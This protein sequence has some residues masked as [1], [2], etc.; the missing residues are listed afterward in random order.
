MS[1]VYVAENSL[2]LEGVDMAAG[3]ILRQRF[4]SPRPWLAAVAAVVA[5]VVLSQMTPAGADPLSP[6]PT[7]GTTTGSYRTGLA[8]AGLVQ[9]TSLAPAHVF[10]G[11]PP[12]AG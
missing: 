11:V 10:L 3:R 9:V 5:A 2:V 7:T 4:R 8:T 1:S 6:S 12:A